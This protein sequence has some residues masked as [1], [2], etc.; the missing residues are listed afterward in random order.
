MTN[1]ID[2]LEPKEHPSASLPPG[3]RR[4]E[5]FPR[6]GTHLA[7]PAPE[8]PAAPVIH[9]GGV[10][11]E[12]FDVPLATLA[13][14]P[15]HELT[16]DFHCVA[17]WSATDLRWEGVTFDDF[18]RRIIEP[19]LPPGMAITHV[20]FR[21][22]D[23]YYSVV[24]IEDAR[25]ADVLL[26]ERLNGRPLDSDHGVPVRLVS[27][28]QYGYIST[29]HLC[30]IDVHTAKPKRSRWSLVGELLIASHPRARVCEEERHGYLPGW[31]VRPIYR[32]VKAPILYVCTRTSSGRRR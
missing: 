31:L 27:P 18:Y 29:K 30:R 7:K 10:V 13:E 20:T 6:F 15:R 22:L 32:A 14:L 17:G 9:I 16:A 5:G 12:A 3:Q 4:I 25:A 26:A 1:L 24:C 8:V 28:A 23:G 19:A 11:T 2:A 21:G